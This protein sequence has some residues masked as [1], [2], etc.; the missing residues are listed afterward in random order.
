MTAPDSPIYNFLREIC[1]SPNDDFP[2]LKYCDWL[3]ENDRSEACPRC[4]AISKYVVPNSLTIIE[5][6]ICHGSG[7]VS[8]GFGARAE[9][10][11]VQIALA[12]LPTRH[13]IGFDVCPETKRKYGNLAIPQ[14][15]GYWT[16]YCR[17]PLKVSDR[18]DLLWHN[19]S[20]KKMPI[21]H[22]LL[23]TQVREEDYVVKKDAESVPDNRKA[24]QDRE[25]E[26][27]TPILEGPAPW[28]QAGLV[29]LYFSGPHSFGYERGFVSWTTLT[30]TDFLQHAQALFDPAKGGQPV[31]KVVLSDKRPVPYREW[32]A[33]YCGEHRPDIPI[34]NLPREIANHLSGGEVNG[35]WFDYTS[36]Q[37]ALDALSDACVR[38]G[39][40]KAGLKVEERIV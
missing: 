32:H 29:P 2:R 37:L 31:M 3:D 11:R 17:E 40:I 14:G 13:L 7:Q 35:P 21:E 25:R 19:R 4:D 22:G 15:E 39:R 6:P 8:N 30:C 1:E 28:D 16:L 26:L 18:I 20:G 12:K 5:C 38:L 34:A 33:W 36:Q 23:V 27:L 24:L 10:I 9:F